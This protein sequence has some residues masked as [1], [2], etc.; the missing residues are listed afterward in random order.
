VIEKNAIVKGNYYSGNRGDFCRIFLW[1]L[2]GKKMKKGNKHY[3][4]FL[5][6]P[7]SE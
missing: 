1:F 7:F 6:Q 5:Q 3:S 4:E 2:R